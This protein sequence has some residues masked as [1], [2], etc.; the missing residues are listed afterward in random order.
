MGN[1]AI[2]RMNEDIGIWLQ[3]NGGELSVEAFLGAARRYGL[4]NDPAGHGTARLVQLI[5]NFFGGRLSVC[6]Q[7]MDRMPSPDPENGIY[8][9]SYDMT[10]EDREQWDG[11]EDS[12]RYDLDEFI[13][14]LQVCNDTFFNSDFGLAVKQA[15][16]IQ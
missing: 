1:R 14:L 4:K 13:A 12:S 7:S 9:I 15:Q 5:G 16:N 2:L 3:W 11:T 10:I 6:V 8:V